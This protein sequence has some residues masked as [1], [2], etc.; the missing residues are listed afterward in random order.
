MS[1]LAA[2]RRSY[3]ATQ[4]LPRPLSTAVSSRGAVPY[5]I[6][7]PLVPPV[8]LLGWCGTRPG[9]SLPFFRPHLPVVLPPLFTNTGFFFAGLPYLSPNYTSYQVAP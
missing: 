1:S 7:K 6:V 4:T 8:L 3:A 2:C 5:F 9:P